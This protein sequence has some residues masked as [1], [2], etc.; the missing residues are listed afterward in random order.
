M[1]YIAGTS[2]TEFTCQPFDTCDQLAALG[3]E[4]REFVDTEGAT[5]TPL[6]SVESGQPVI[7][8]FSEDSQ[9]Y[10]GEVVTFDSLNHTAEVLFIDYGKSE[11]VP[12]KCI[13][14][15]PHKFLQLP[16]QAVMCSLFGV[17]PMTE[18]G[19]WGSKAL[20]KLH[21][22]ANSC[23]YMTAKI[24]GLDSALV[25]VKI[26]SDYCVDFAEELIACELAC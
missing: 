8:Q 22:L 20:E 5:S 13:Y 21:E 19:S 11:N 14:K 18:D 1:L 3:D 2:P 9:W 10:R 7:A 16:K 25:L 26:S 24:V 23:E 17:K 6:T 12:L 4:I 15:M